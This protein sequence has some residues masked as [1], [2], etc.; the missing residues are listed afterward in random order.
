MD[1][2]HEYTV[3]IKNKECKKFFLFAKEDLDT[4]YSVRHTDIGESEAKRN[5]EKR[6]LRLR[7]GGIKV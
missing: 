5:P 3:Y 7:G 6:D 2:S 1:K 4:K